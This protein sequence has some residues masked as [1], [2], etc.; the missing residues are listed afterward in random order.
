MN[1]ARRRLVGLVAILILSACTAAAKPPSPSPGPGAGSGGSVGGEKPIG[2]RPIGT[3]P[4]GAVPGQPGEPLLVVP[5]PGQANVHPA[6]VTKLE[7]S[8]TAG[9]AVAKASW[10]SG[11]EPCTKL[12]SVVVRHEERTILITIR[13]GS[14]PDAGQ[15]ACIEIAVLKATVID[16]GSPAPG[17][18]TVRAT[19][20]DAPHVTFTIR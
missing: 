12:D 9:K 19:D 15:V 3:H 13:E 7:V 10:W 16:L 4:I 6:S 17:T 18:Y 5:H 20:G 2:D 11:I 8:V 1:M 14:P